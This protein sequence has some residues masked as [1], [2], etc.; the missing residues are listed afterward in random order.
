V[1][2]FVAADGERGA[3]IAA[4]VGDGLITTSPKA[5]V[6]ETF[7]REG[8]AGKPKYGQVT[9]CYGKDEEAAK[10]TAHKYWPT[11]ALPSTPMWEIRSPR[12]FEALVE[13]VTVEQVAQEIVCGPDKQRQIEAIGTYVEAGFDHVYVHQV[14][15]DQDAFFDFYSREVLPELRQRYGGR[16]QMRRTA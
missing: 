8:G 16:E 13:N 9:V 12:H 14:G 7:D 15:P 10:K 4:T 5:E 1:K 2:V 6:L 11:S 3:R